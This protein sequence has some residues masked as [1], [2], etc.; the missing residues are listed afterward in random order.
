MTLDG[1]VLPDKPAGAG[2]WK[3]ANPLYS[4]EIHLS[5]ERALFNPEERSLSRTTADAQPERTQGERPCSAELVHTY[6][7]SES[8]KISLVVLDKLP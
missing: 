2:A 5:I 4:I 3:R 6:C 8:S 1:A 7:K